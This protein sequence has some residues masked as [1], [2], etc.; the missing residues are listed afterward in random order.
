MYIKSIASI[1]MKMTTSRASQYVAVGGT[2]FWTILLHACWHPWLLWG[3]FSDPWDHY[4]HV[5]SISFLA[6]AS[7]AVCMVSG[8]CSSCTHRQITAMFPPE[9]ISSWIMDCCSHLNC[10]G[11]ISF[12]PHV[13]LEQG[14]VCSG[15]TTPAVDFFYGCHF[16]PLVMW[17]RIFDLTEYRKKRIYFNH[18]YSLIAIY[19]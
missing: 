10:N 1:W 17:P 15:L 7:R 3:R 4:Q 12:L 14:E 9:R 2:G 8:L 13:Q 16:H 19:L 18:G 5:W 6:T 11:Y